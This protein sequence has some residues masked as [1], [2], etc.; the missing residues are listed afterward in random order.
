MLAISPLRPDDRE[1]LGDY[2]LRGRIAET[3]RSVSYAAESGSGERTVV[4]LYDVE[5]DDPDRF[6]TTIDALQRLPAFC[7]VPILDAG[8]VTGR[9]YI[10]TEHVDGPTLVEE[11]REHG[12]LAGPALHRLAVGTVTALVAVH[13]TGAVH[14]G[15]RPDAVL[16]SP[17]GPRVT[18]TGL[19]PILE[20]A[21]TATT[22][23][24][25]ALSP[26]TP[27]TLI[28][29]APGQPA[30]MFSWAAAMVFAATGRHPFEAD[31][32]AESVNR[33]LNEN[34]DL[35]ALDEPLRGLVAR[36][37]AKDPAERPGSSDALLTLVGHSLL[38]ARLDL[39][40]IGLPSPPGP[41]AVGA[42]SD[43]ASPDA[44][45]S[46]DP[47][48][49]AAPSS[50]AAP[51]IAAASA[52]PGEP[53]SSPAGRPTAVTPAAGTPRAV[54]W[55]GWLGYAL[56]GLA[57]AL[58]SGGGVYAVVSR[59]QP[60]A[61]PASSAA[62]HGL[63]AE[64]E[65]PARRGLRRRGPGGQEG[66]LHPGRRPRRGRLAVPLG[67]GRL[68]R[69]PPSRPGQGRGRRLCPRRHRTADDPR[70][71]VDRHGAG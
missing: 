51:G 17:D 29:D 13:Q 65:D 62:A 20:A 18:G 48:S 28:G 4:T 37:L 66:G 49:P 43:P 30:D 56:A 59:Q 32:A 12:P 9:P 60:T 6:L 14:G 71:A 39:G 15:L 40:K 22:Q 69:H 31:S 25:T 57:I 21:S 47:A 36:C 11:V 68:V 7:L 67:P 5:L 55:W 45:S 2:R 10:V 26:L 24:V 38:T 70:G 44:P 35:P 8:T 16:L 42:P 61:T 58:A 41:T 27:E 1:R 64:R 23:P 33:V 63:D 50:P 46:P 34:P 19:A 53:S 54:P 3:V 52:S